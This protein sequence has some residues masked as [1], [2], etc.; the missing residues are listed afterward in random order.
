MPRHAKRQVQIYRAIPTIAIGG[1][2]QRKNKSAAD[3]RGDTHSAL[4]ICSEI[5]LIV[6]LE[7]KVQ[8]HPF[9]S[10]GIV[11]EGGQDARVHHCFDRSLG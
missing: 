5:L 8:E 3:D 1:L 2:G 9:G 10:L 4:P 7:T 6:D 11:Q